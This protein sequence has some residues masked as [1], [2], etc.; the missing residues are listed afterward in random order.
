MSY[1]LLV[2]RTRH[3][4]T[5]C[6]SWD[7]AAIYRI[8]LQ[9]PGL[10]GLRLLRASPSVTPARHSSNV[11]Q[12]SIP[13]QTRQLILCISNDNGYVDGFVRVLTSAKRLS[14]NFS[15]GTARTSPA[16]DTFRNAC[17]PIQQLSTFNTTW[18]N[19]IRDN[20]TN[21]HAHE[22]VC[23]HTLSWSACWNTTLESKLSHD[24]L[25]TFFFVI[26]LKPGVE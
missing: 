20:G 7:M 9:H 12:K 8:L 18:H 2:C 17:T 4:R 16:S 1:T 21:A 13:A 24:S 10:L 11:L 15:S 3:F 25:R 14:K 19:G 22:C 23:A 6:V 26:F 5:R